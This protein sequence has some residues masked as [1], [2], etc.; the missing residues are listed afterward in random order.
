[1]S[2]LISMFEKD[3][4]PELSYPGGKRTRL[5]CDIAVIGGGG[6]GV[7][8]A[9]RAAQLG[10][11]VILIEK[12]EDLGGNTKFA[13]GLLSTTSAPQRARGLEDQ[14]EHYFKSA[15]QTHHYTLDPRLFKRYIQNTGRYFEWLIQLGLDEENLKFVGDGIVM[16]KNRLDPGPLYNPCYGPGLMGSTSLDVLKPHLSSLGVTC[17]LKTKARSLI[18]DEAGAVRGLTADGQDCS[19]EIQ[20]GATILASGGFGGNQALLR[21]FLPQYFTSD[22]Y[23]SHYYLLSSTGDGIEMAEQIGAEVGRNICAGIAPLVHNPAAY[24]VQHAVFHNPDGLIVNRNGKRFIAEDDVEDGEFAVDMQPEGLAFMIFDEAMKQPFFQYCVDTTGFDD[25]VPTYDQYLKDLAQEA[26]EG[27]IA[28]CDTLDAL[29]D[30]IGCPAQALAGTVEAY[31]AMC[32]ARHDTEL[33]KAPEH[34]VPI[35]SP[36]YYAV[37]MQRNCDVTMGGVSINY[38]LEVVRPDQ[39]PIPGLYAT[40]DVASGWMSKEYGPAFSS[41]AWALNSGYLAAEE[42]A[43]A[44]KLAPSPSGSR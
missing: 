40:G 4:K 9:V 6:A 35:S 27:K 11:R 12:M 17:L 25:P 7:S 32:G 43:C 22:H 41:L 18:T 1:M 5:E 31:N 34:L 10:A 38:R 42:A 29:A 8:A 39:T 26:Q 36:P 20:A 13:G 2:K 28:I 44:L 19:Y 15:F 21:R 16:V 24:S 37:R 30:F 33:F 3:D 14:T 23:I